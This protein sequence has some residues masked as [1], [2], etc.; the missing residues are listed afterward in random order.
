MKDEEHKIQTEFFNI[1]RMSESKNPIL[2]YIF[3]IPNGSK[4][5][6]GVAKKL[7]A[8]GVKRGVPD[9][10]VPISSQQYAGM[11]IEFKSEKGKLSKEQKEYIGHLENEGYYC[12]VCRT[13]CDAITKLEKYLSIQIFE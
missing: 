6:I 13:S 7:K 9:V 11:F 12:V 10:A 5:S 8:E 3:A 2:K 1:L 4:R